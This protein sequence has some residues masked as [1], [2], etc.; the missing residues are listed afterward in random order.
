MPL[1]DDV[2]SLELDTAFRDCVVDGD[3]SPLFLVAK[4]LTKLQSM[5][6]LIP[7]VQVWT[8]LYLQMP[9]G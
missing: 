4:A 8:G 3:S 6:G 9:S 5:F 7:R 2:L 1:E